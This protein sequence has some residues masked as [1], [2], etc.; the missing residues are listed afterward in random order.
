MVVSWWV[1]A[2]LPSVHYLPVMG[3]VA[4]IVPSLL[5]DGVVEHSSNLLW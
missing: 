2:F 5:L 1:V 3:A 4:G